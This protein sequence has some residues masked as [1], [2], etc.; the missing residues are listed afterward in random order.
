MAGAHPEDSFI[1]FTDKNIQHLPANCRVE[2]ISPKPKNKLLM[3]YWYRYKL[4]AL[5]I[6]N[7]ATCF[8]SDAEMLSLRPTIAQYLYFE[9][10]VA[11][12]KRSKYFE[13]AFISSLQ[14]ATAIFTAEGYIEDKLKTAYPFTAEKIKTTWHGL[15]FVS[16]RSTE[17][18]IKDKYAD[19]FDY[20]LCPV[21]STAPAHLIVLLK[22]FSQFKKRQKT[23]LKLV[24]LLHDIPADKFLPQLRTYK[25]EDEVKVVGKTED[26]SGIISS[27]FAVILLENGPAADAA[28]FAMQQHVCVAVPMNPVS[29][30]LFGDAVFFTEI[31]EALLSETMQLIYKNEATKAY[32][33]EKGFIHAAR[34]DAEHAARLMYDLMK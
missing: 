34:Y 20:F 29:K 19:G 2:I 27:A 5:L 18:E 6:K 9:N 25:Y 14:K 33:E 31:S 22:A 28:L 11:S 26:L 4:P 24:F 3:Y 21:K 15:P 10:S 7:N 12:K 16:S 32:F 23:S 8:I 13:K 17:Q 1:F 30:S